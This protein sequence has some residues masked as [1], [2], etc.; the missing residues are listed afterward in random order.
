M[1]A[2]R[3]RALASEQAARAAAETSN[4]L[5][6]EFLAVV[7]HELRSPLNAMLGWVQMLRAGRLNETMTAKALETIE[8]NARAQ[9]QLIE[10][11]LDVSRII[12][13]KIRLNVRS[14]ELVPIIEAAIDTV[15]LAA[16][17]KEVRLQSILDPWAGPVSGDSERLQ[18]VIWN[19]L[20]NAI[21]FTPKKGRVQIRLERINSHVEITVSDTGIGISLDFQ[22]YVFERFRQ[23]DSSTTRSY[24]G[25]GLGLALV[26]HLVELHGGTV[27]VA[28]PGVGQGT[29]FIVKLP[30]MP[31]V[32]LQTTDLGRVHP[33]ISSGVPF[34][35]LP[36][37]EGVRV[38]VVDDEADT[39]DFITT[40]LAECGAEVKA[41]ESAAKVLEAIP[42]WQPDIL[43]SDIG[44]PEEDGYSLL[45]KVRALESKRERQIPAVA[46]TAYARVEDRIQALS[47]G[48]GQHVTKP[49]EPAEL[50]AVI[51][52]LARQSL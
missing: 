42:Q 11:L 34:D 7:S 45:C 41:V 27:A 43:V 46:L 8:R 20:S 17:A 48:F 9:T 32:R 47:A 28:S 5:K 24:N 36:T 50:V 33:T 29:T 49:V 40:V 6:D 38:L 31:V 26:R 4:R 13:G 22:P 14:C 52:N 2:E 44:M 51:A 23:E 35:N 16:D 37:L 30:L 25:L 3:D 21:K 10:D 19:L 12:T 39:R 18:Q 1:I 15:R